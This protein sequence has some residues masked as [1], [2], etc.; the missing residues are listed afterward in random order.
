MHLFSLCFPCCFLRRPWPPY[1]T[2]GGF[3][4][5][6]EAHDVF[7]AARE[8]AANNHM[9]ANASELLLAFPIMRHFALT[10]I[11]PTGRLASETNSLCALCALV[12]MYVA[13]KRGARGDAMVKTTA[14]LEA[15][16][17]PFDM[18]CA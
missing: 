16:K 11:R 17:V 13:A 5:G 1:D 14:F 9:K 4:S 10:V 15:H 18:P 6:S 7:S 2:S 3:L 8:K 12:D